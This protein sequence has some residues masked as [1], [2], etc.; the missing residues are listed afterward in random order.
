MK[1][2]GAFYAFC[3]S[4]T[5]F[6]E[7]P[8]IVRNQFTCIIF[9]VTSLLYLLNETI[10]KHEQKYDFDID[11]INTVFN[12]FYVDDFVG[13]ENSLEGAFL[14][15]KKSKLCFLEGLFHLKKWRTNDLK[16]REFISD[17]NST[18]TSKVLGILWDE[19]K[20]TFIYDLKGICELAHSLSLT[21]R[22]LLRVLAAYYDPLWM[23]QHIIK[24]KIMF[25]QIC[26]LNLRWDSV[27]PNNLK[28]TF[29]CLQ[30]FLKENE[31][32]EVPHIFDVD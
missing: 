3:G 17:S 1:R 25:Q 11:F 7:Q 14:L 29:F 6:S 18:E 23:L 32:I 22:N 31:Q 2:I 10:C 12:L 20:H 15:F 9:D 8:K 4:D 24:M 21:K 13:G 16:L 28:Q 26:K 30:S 19:C 5:V 27:L